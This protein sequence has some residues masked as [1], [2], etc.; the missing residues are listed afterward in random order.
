MLETLKRYF[1]Y[2]IFRPLQQ[3]AI[4][5]VLDGKDSLVLMPTGGGKSLCYQIPALMMEGTAVVVSPLI[6]LMQDQV[7]ALNA[8][9]IPAAALN[10][11]QGTRQNKQT[12]M[13]AVSGRL[14]L[15]YVSPERLMLDLGE[16]QLKPADDDIQ[17]EG[18]T[19]FDSIFKQIRISMFA[20]DEAHCVSQ[21]GHDF[22]PE[23]KML[24]RL[25]QIFP[26]VPMMALTA[27]ADK[28][29]KRDIVQ[30]LDLHNPEIFTLSFD[31]PNLSLDVRCGC[32]SKTKLKTILSLIKRHEGESGIIYCLA[33]KT[34]E[35]LAEKLKEAGV[36]AAAYHASLSAKDRTQVQEDFKQGRIDV[37]CATIAFGMGI[38]KPD[39]RFVIHYNMP[40]SIESFYQEI[41]RGGRDGKPCETLLFYSIGDIVALKQVARDTWHQNLNDDKMWRMQQ[42][43]EARVCRRRIL[44]NY[45]G[46]ESSCGCGNCDVCRNPPQLYDGTMQVQ[47]A[48][49]AVI[50]TNQG[51]SASI[52]IDILKGRN[53][54]EIVRRG[55]NELP[56]FGVGHELTE[57]EWKDCLLQMLQMGFIDVDYENFRQLKITP[58]GINTLK[59]R[60]RIKLAMRRKEE[61]NTPIET[62]GLT[63]IKLRNVATF[64]RDGV[65]FGNL[66]PVSIIYGGNGTGKS[67]LTKVVSDPTAYP[68]CE[69]EWSD[70]DAMPVM[71]YDHRFRQSNISENMPGV[72]T[73]GE[74]SAQSSEEIARVREEL[75]TRKA[76]CARKRETISETQALM[77]KNEENF[78]E[79]AWSNIK[80]SVPEEFKMAL[81]GAMTKDKFLVKLMSMHQEIGLAMPHDWNELRQR[82]MVVYQENTPATKEKASNGV[83][84]LSHPDW[85]HEGM[86]HLMEGDDKCPFCQQHTI[87]AYLRWMLATYF[88][89]QG[90]QE[91]AHIGQM[92]ENLDEERKQLTRDVW[93]T[94]IRENLAAI[95]T[96]L[97]KQSALR[98]Q[99]TTYNTELEQLRQKCT[100]LEQQITQYESTLTSIK[101]TITRINQL[102]EEHKYDGFRLAESPVDTNCYQI[103]RNDGTPAG[104]TLSEGEATLITFLYFM[105][106]AKGALTQEDAGQPRILVIDDPVDALDQK[107]IAIV[108]SLIN[109]QIDEMRQGEGL[110][111][112]IILLTHNSQLMHALTHPNGAFL[113]SRD[114][115]F[116]TLTKSSGTTNAEAHNH[117][118]PKIATG[119]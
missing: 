92:M 13:D 46:E 93:D 30:L 49:S 50:R 73:L 67:T 72:F 38:D 2:E 22:R 44:L 112:Q 86:K 100:E 1:G 83:L 95:N 64:D 26:T 80:K 118:C 17:F 11:N 85:V 102:L 59:E 77:K 97:D 3:E 62:R 99:E 105:Q 14:K 91:S 115:R 19:W 9:G 29:T 98:Q 74:A 7:N 4:Q 40:K 116:W 108:N 15:I 52:V 10:S 56:T 106:L 70:F 28:L 18:M 41:G 20:I 119:S 78:R 63:T 33:R 16:T 34:T 57:K 58:L 21:W 6:S 71:A 55:Y 36:N 54:A 90:K 12:I 76:E 45:F 104:I 117:E 82:A 113:P 32:D 96:Y 39:V 89:E 94:L 75:E 101:P 88:G 27:T 110:V 35:T 31:R 25:R 47:M 66:A 107:G 48:L 103:V 53:N 8:R 69:L 61:E 81:Q 111:T 68:D 84:Q 109:A 114:I 37:I 65:T 87:T 23:Y 43:A 79:Y 60:S 5:T 24:N 51:A 42:Y